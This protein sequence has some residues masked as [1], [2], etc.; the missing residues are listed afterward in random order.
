MRVKT[1]QLFTR[2]ADLVACIFLFPGIWISTIETVSFVNYD[3]AIFCMYLNTS[4]FY[5][6]SWAFL[7]ITYLLILLVRLWIY[8]PPLNIWMWSLGSLMLPSNIECS[9]LCRILTA[10]FWFVL[11]VM[12]EYSRRCAR[13]CMVRIIG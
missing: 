3:K 8:Y 4:M 12:A 7:P 6:V 10:T 13:N 2:V 9:V 11:Y 1:K 5:V